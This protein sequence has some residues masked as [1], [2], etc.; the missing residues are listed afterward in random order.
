MPKP[1]KTN[2]KFTQAEVRHI[3]CLL[4]RNREMPEMP[5]DFPPDFKERWLRAHESLWKKFKSI[6]RRF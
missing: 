5:R 1:R 6:D 4:Y 2:L 3:V